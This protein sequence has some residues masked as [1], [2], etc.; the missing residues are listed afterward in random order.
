MKNKK[1]IKNEKPIKKEKGKTHKNFF[2][3]IDF[4]FSHI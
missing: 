4:L 3:K 2:H 1:P